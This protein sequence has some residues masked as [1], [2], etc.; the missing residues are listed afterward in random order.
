LREHPTSLVEAARI[1][2][3][4]GLALNDAIICAWKGKYKHNLIRPIAYIKRYIDSTWEPA[5]LTPPF[6]EFPSGHSVQSAAMATVLT[7]LIGENVSY[8]DY[9]KYW[10]GKPRKFNSF[11][12]AAN[13]TSVSRLYGGIHFKDALDQG[14]DMGKLV[15]KNV[16][17]LKF[18]K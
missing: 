1:Y 16:L 12:E 13:E 15:G 10:V 4:L 11:W 7:S 9:S 14:Q 5:L 17:T 2:C 18:K 3:T 6:P 8:T